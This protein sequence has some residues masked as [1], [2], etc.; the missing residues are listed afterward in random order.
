M[1]I[2]VIYHL[3]HLNLVSIV[4]KS[5]LGLFLKFSFLVLIDVCLVFCSC[6]AALSLFCWSYRKVCDLRKLHASKKDLSLTNA[7]TTV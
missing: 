4:N 1:T 3:N 2:G 6:L 5:M 7:S